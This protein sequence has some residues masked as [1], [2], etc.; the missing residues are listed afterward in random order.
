MDVELIIVSSLQKIFPLSEVESPL[1]KATMLKD[2]RYSFQVAVRPSERI[3]GASLELLG[4]EKEF[5]RIR[6][7]ALAPA[8]QTEIEKI[9]GTIGESA[10]LYPDILVDDDCKDL[11]LRGGMWCSF[12]VTAEML[13]VGEHVFTFCIRNAEGEVLASKYFSLHVLSQS[14]ST[15]EVSYSNW[16]HYD[17]I[18]NY[19]GK[20]PFTSA[21]YKILGKYLD[22][23]L[24]H[25]VNVLYT[26]LFTPPLDTDIGKERKTIQLVDVTLKE[27]K[28]IFDFK[29][30]KTFINFAKRHGFKYFEF[31]HLFS[32]W[33]AR[34][35]PKVVDIEDNI[36]FNWNDFSDGEKYLSFLDA[37]LKEFNLFI[38]KN[39]LKGKCYY[40]I[41][42]EPSLQCIERYEKLASFVRPRL[43]NA[44]L[45]DALS[46]YEFYEKGLVD[47]PVVATSEVNP[48]LEKANNFWVYYC[49]GQ[50]KNGLSNRFFN[51]PSARNRSLGVQLYRN[52]VKG[53]LHWGYNFYNGY[54]SKHAIDPYRV[55]DG[56]GGFQAG[57][58]FI[59]YPGEGCVVDSIRHEVF[60]EGLQD[61]RALMKL[62]ELKGR[63]VALKILDDYDIK[64]GFENS[65]C[66]EKKFI[67][68]REKI[69]AAIKS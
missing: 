26:P 54:L 65:L 28:Y 64:G 67:E 15:K 27:E 59:V 12:W 19:Y 44:K 61:Y 57:D 42:D 2:E 34:Y 49:C 17:C 7:V 35:A 51:F 13:S 4:D 63:E 36:L 62:E 3:L 23:A 52:E 5:C 60:Y 10:T 68:L 46:C 21:Y 32:Q 33:G 30:L 6:R 39:K 53:F 56:D 9:E 8:Y 40:H 43:T 20:K 18:S 29:K 45:M 50:Y 66:D 1:L 11:A 14:L 41:S 16:M 47:L 31:S 55:T 48:F 22:N 24:S 25:G 58:A 38:E 69:N 37:F